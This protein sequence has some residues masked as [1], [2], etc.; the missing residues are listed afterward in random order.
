MR[1]WLRTGKGAEAAAQAIRFFTPPNH[2]KDLL[3]MVETFRVWNDEVTGIPSYM[4][5]DSDVSG[6][7]K[8]AS[9]LS[10]LMSAANLTLKDALENFD[11]GIT[12]PFLKEMYSWNMRY[13]E[14]EAIKGDYEVKAKGA[15]SLVAKEV[16]VNNLQN[17]MSITANEMD[18]NI[19]DRRSMLE[20]ILKEMELPEH[21]L[22]PE[23]ETDYI[24]QLEQALQQMQQQMQQAAQMEGPSAEGQM[25]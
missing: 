21:I 10:M 1:T 20:E 18:Q 3:N 8:T 17:F 16:R 11:Q 5:G 6:A 24:K 13:E 19:I 9:G 2:T 23:E 25:Q 12:V 15:S 7:G 22:R 14:D 4:H